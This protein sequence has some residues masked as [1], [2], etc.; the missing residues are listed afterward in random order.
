MCISF[1]NLLF[2]GH[3]HSNVVTEKNLGFMLGGQGMEGNGDYGIPV[4]DTTNDH[5]EINYFPINDATGL[6]MYQQVYDCFV[7]NP[8]RNCLHLSRSWLNQTI[9]SL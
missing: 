9:V 8:Y 7:N 2:S 1:H 3:E 4:I 5:V 6:D